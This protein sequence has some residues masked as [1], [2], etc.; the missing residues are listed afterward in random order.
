MIK[1]VGPGLTRTPKAVNYG[2]GLR[3][4]CQSTRDHILTF[5]LQPEPEKDVSLMPRNVP[6]SEESATIRLFD[7]VRAADPSVPDMPVIVATAIAEQIDAIPGT[8]VTS[9]PAASYGVVAPPFKTFFVEAQT[10]VEI[11]GQ[12]HVVDRGMIVTDMS[13]IVRERGPVPGTTP[14][15]GTH[16]YLA[17]YGYLYMKERGLQSYTGAVVLIHLDKEGYILDDTERLQVFPHTSTG[18]RRSVLARMG[19]A[20]SAIIPI[21]Y[22]AISAMHQ[23]C[24]VDEVTPPRICPPRQ[25]RRAGASELE[26][27]KYY[28]L[29]V[30]PI[31]PASPEDFRRIGTPT[32]TG[33]REHRIRGHFKIYTEAAPLFGKYV[34]T[35]WV[36]EHTR[37]DDSYGDIKKDYKV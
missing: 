3:V 5:A 14:P 16:F 32:R 1:R 24:A 13:Q 36:P 15:A 29:Q 10:S 31:V 17:N 6:P 19:H 18:L 26:R 30:K 8:E 4:E 21:V 35:V 9:Y 22:K 7:R 27:H 34:R 23:R 20:S 2:Y 12:R 28:V 33:T 11:Q 37:G 25:A